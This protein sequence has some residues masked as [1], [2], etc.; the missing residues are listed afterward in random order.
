MASPGHRCECPDSPGATLLP[1]L[2]RDSIGCISSSQFGF[3][4]FGAQWWGGWLTTPM[5]LLLSKDMLIGCLEVAGVWA[6]LGSAPQDHLT[7]RI[8]LHFT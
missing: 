6:V 5:S 1:C 2:L 4:S 7:S 8:G 3:C